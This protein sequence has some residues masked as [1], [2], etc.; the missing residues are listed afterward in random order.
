[1]ATDTRTTLR[2]M[3]E[4]LVAFEH[5]DEAAAGSENDGAATATAAGEDTGAAAG[6][7][8][9]VVPEDLSA[10]SDEELGALREQA[11]AHFD[12]IYGDGSGLS[13]EDLDTLASLTD[14]IDAMNAETAARAEA[15][16]Q[17]EAAA[18]ELAARVRPEA[19]AAAETADEAGDDDGGDGEA[20]GDA[21]A[22]GAE[23]QAASSTTVTAAASSTSGPGA[24]GR[25]GAGARISLGSVRQRG[26]AA[27]GAGGRHP[28]LP[29]MPLTPT[30]V[31]QVLYRA[32][33]PGVGIDVSTLANDLDQRLT[34]FNL[35]AYSQAA[36]RGVHMRQQDSLAFIRKP[37]PSDLTVTS[38]DPS[39]VDEVLS[40]ATSQARLPQSSLVAAGGWCAPSE[41]LWDL[42][43]LETRAGLLSLPE[44][45]AAR[46][47]FQWTT[48]PDFSEIF[49]N[50]GWTFTEEHDIEGTY[51]VDENGDGNG[52]AGDKPCWRIPCPEFE[53]QRLGI[54]GLCLVAGLLQRRGFPESIARVIRGALIAHDHKMAARY[55]AQMVLGS[56]PVVL[57]APQVGAT[58]PVLTAIELQAQHVR[59]LHRMSENATLE[60]VFPHW[61]FGVVRADLARRL[62]VDLIAVPDSRIRGW[63]SQLNINAQ[64]IYNYQDV[65]GVSAQDFTSWPDAIQFL[66]YPAGTWVKAT[67]DI[68]TLDT[69]YDSLLLGQNDYVALFT[70]EGWMVMKR[71]IDSRAVTVPLNASGGTHGGVVILH[72]GTPAAPDAGDGEGEGGGEGG[73]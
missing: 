19:A 62:G 27:A 68:I 47:G 20:G 24:S 32:D 18:A 35:S 15:A 11:L 40:R 67:N 26:A 60:A 33:S 66:L 2:R 56:T 54:N 36:Q 71:G 6:G 30:N 42:L 51:G 28:G 44:V 10:L 46:G 59:N 13:A 53:E 64:F 43:E 17:R 50:V 65:A 58:A 52:E 38:N 37:I 21:S 7:D 25:R 12:T 45:I 48:G 70:E 16:S 5:D 4:R 31:N 49:A 41:I 14:A 9:F 63:F 8:E 69:I 22:G 29:Q 72:D 73:E 3:A 1:M 57:P 55:I 61:V 23:S 34:R 39:H